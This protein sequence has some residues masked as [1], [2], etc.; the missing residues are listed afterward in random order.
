MTATIRTFVATAIVAVLSSPALAQT[1][2]GSPVGAGGGLGAAVAPLGLRA[3]SGARAAVGPAARAAASINSARARFVNATGGGVPEASPAGGTVTVP[4]PAA[5]ALG[6]VLSGSASPAQL[7]TLSAA[8]GGGT[9]AGALI[10]ALQAFVAN[11][12]N[13]SYA[14]AVMRLNTVIRA[15]PPG[16]VPSA[17]LVAVRNL[18][19][20]N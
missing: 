6:A 12:S 2:F 20:G 9:R 7:Q 14:T 10:T 8:L 5:Q 19:A 13:D 3:N 16:Q 11:S 4:A 17:T 18:L 1:D 15:T